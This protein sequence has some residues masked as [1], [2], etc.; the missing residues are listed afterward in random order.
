[1]NPPYRLIQLFCLAAVPA[2]HST[3]APKGPLDDNSQVAIEAQSTE[4]DLKSDIAVMHHVRMSRLD[5]AL[6]ADSGHRA[7]VEHDQGARKWTIRV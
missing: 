5:F 6:S 4:L 7:T 1:V 2:A 3:A